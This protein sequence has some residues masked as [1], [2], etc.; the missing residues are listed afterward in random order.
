LMLM[1]RG[2]WMLCRSSE[3]KFSGSQIQKGNWLSDCWWWISLYSLCLPGVRPLPF[4]CLLIP[5]VVV[6]CLLAVSIR[7]RFPV[8][9]VWCPA[10]SEWEWGSGST[11]S[12]WISQWI[13]WFCG[14]RGGLDLCFRLYCRVHETSWFWY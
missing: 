9:L 13:V 10:K 4:T 7:V 6:S 11:P 1:P 12:A 8:D 2:I 14:V 3:T 5:T